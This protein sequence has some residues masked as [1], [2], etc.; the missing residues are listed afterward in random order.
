M[1]EFSFHLAK[2]SMLILCK[3][4]ACLDILLLR[5]LELLLLCCCYGEELRDCDWWMPGVYS[6]QAKIH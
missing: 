4:L 2:E 1:Q 6:Q 3:G 5:L